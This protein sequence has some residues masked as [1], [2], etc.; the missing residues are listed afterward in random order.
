MARIKHNDPE[1]LVFNL[2]GTTVFLDVTGGVVF[3][4][5]FTPAQAVVNASYQ[6]VWFYNQHGLVGEGR[7]AL[8]QPCIGPEIVESSANSCSIL[9]FDYLWHLTPEYGQLSDGGLE[10]PEVMLEC[11]QA[12][13][14][15]YEAHTDVRAQV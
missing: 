14:D 5:H 8:T 11:G 2:F 10:L 4:D 6:T 1:R 9:V 15:W 12:V 7:E 13:I 3:C